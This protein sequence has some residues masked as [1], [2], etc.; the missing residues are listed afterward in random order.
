MEELLQQNF[1]AFER[2]TLQYLIVAPLP[3]PLPP[4]FISEIFVNIKSIL[5][6]SF[7]Y[8]RAGNK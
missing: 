5:H 8:H 2:E 6:N 7:N 4:I 1:S 3:R